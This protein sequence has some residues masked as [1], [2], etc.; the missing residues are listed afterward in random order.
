MRLIYLLGLI[1]YL[2]S[3]TLI[4]QTNIRAQID[5]PLHLKSQAVFSTENII[6]SE[7]F[8]EQKLPEN[9]TDTVF[10]TEKTWTFQPLPDYPFSDIINGDL[11]S[12]I[13]PWVNDTIGQNEWLIS[14]IIALPSDPKNIQLDFYAGFSK[15]W[16]KNANLELW[17]GD[18]Q[19]SDTIWKKIWNAASYVD[20]MTANWTWRAAYSSLTTYKGKSI[21]LGFRYTGKNGDLIAIDNIVVSSYD[22]ANEAE[23]L[24]FSLNNQLEDAVIDAQNKKISVK[25]IYGSNFSEII[26]SFTLSAGAT[27]SIKSGDTI[28]IVPGEP[29]EIEVLAEDSVTTS[30][31]EIS[32][33]EAEVVKD[34]DIKSFSIIGQTRAALIDTKNAIIEAEINCK[35][36]PDSLI[37]SFEISKA[38]TSSIQSGDTIS[39]G[40]ES[41]Y[42]ILIDAQDTTVSRT[43]QLIVSVRDYTANILSFSIP[44]QIGAAIID[45]AAN[46]I[47]VQLPYGSKLDSITPNFTLGDCASSMP[48]SGDTVAFT[49]KI[50]K[51]FLVYP[52]NENLAP[53]S[54]KITIQLQKNTLFTQGFDAKDSIP[55]DWKVDTLSTKSWTFKHVPDYPFSTVYKPSKYSAFVPWSATDEQNEWLISDTFDTQSFVDLGIKDVKLG[56]YAGYNPYFSYGFCDLKAY[57]RTLTGQWQLKWQMPEVNENP[58]DWAW[59]YQQI[60]LSTLLG[61]K[62][63]LAFVYAGNNGD[64]IAIDD[65]QVFS[66]P[67][68]LLK[69]EH[70]INSVSFYPNPASDY[71]VLQGEKLTRILLYDL[72]GRMVFGQKNITPGN[73]IRLPALQKGLYLLKM[74]YE[75]GEISIQKLQIQ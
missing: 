1:S 25:M 32:A 56:F 49:N 59:R 41:P 65:I 7:A 40:I 63:Q 64:L 35:T 68:E 70:K 11:A 19:A 15:T 24:S 39:V 34:A 22:K 36:N 44:K 58:Y 61:Q 42:A 28:A 60:D 27:S 73:A 13:C 23:I 47:F 4:A 62:L 26:P 16:I 55:L 54:W 52:Q 45:T 43:W 31:W 67:D 51:T 10:S 17:I 5:K 14:P 8:D 48:A 6:F 9:W 66:E 3:G 69:N 50:P 20:T 38:A 21:K 53:V 71:I 33:I 72:S 30:I 75:T 12:A 57:V 37:V 2:F 29:F 74:Q 46:S 18:F